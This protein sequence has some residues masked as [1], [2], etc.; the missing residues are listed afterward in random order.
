MSDQASARVSAP[1]G[2]I[3]MVAGDASAAHPHVQALTRLTDAQG[4]RN[5]AD[6]LHHLCTVHGRHPGVVD[7]AAT[8]VIDDD[9]ARSMRSLADAFAAE[10]DY[11]AQLVVAAGSRPS[12]PGQS[13]SMASVVAQRHAIDM[14]AQSERGGVAAGAALALVLDWRAIRPVLDAAA[15]RFGVDVAPRRLPAVDVLASL[16]EAL[17]RV[18][19]TARAFA[20][21]AQQIAAQHRGLWDLLSARAKARAAI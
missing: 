21:G 9:T 2:W 11:L 8:R 10:R 1:P 13:E 3:T 15:I 17:C 20:F 18:P 16:G 5:A 7:H 12:T 14:L 19:P 6:A 4:A